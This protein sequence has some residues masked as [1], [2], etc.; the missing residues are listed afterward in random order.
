MLG[1]THYCPEWDFDLI[2]PDTPEM[3]CCLCQE[4]LIV[5]YLDREYAKIEKAK[6]EKVPE[7]KQNK[8]LN[9]ILNFKRKNK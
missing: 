3:E 8:I 7:I 2:H 6:V 5:A 1:I 9:W 4:S